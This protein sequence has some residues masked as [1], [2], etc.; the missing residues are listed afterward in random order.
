M[1]LTDRSIQRQRVYLTKLGLMHTLSPKISLR[2]DNNVSQLESSFRKRS[3]TPPADDP[4]LINS[5]FGS[6]RCATLAQ[7]TLET[8][9]C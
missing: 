6:T 4:A 1:Y 5:W 9:A 8:L 7:F 3:A 2:K